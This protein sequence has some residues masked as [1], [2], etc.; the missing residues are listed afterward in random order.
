VSKLVYYVLTVIKPIAKE[1]YCTAT[2]LLFYIT[3]NKPNH[4]F[5]IPCIPYHMTFQDLKLSGA[6]ARTVLEDIC[7]KSIR[8]Q[9]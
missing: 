6:I 5:H 1:N 9:S 4:N 2:T 8:I 7:D 3:Q